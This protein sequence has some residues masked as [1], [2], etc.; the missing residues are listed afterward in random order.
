MQLNE[1]SFYKPDWILGRS[2]MVSALWLAAVQPPDAWLWHNHVQSELYST[3]QHQPNLDLHHPSNLQN[4][5]WNQ[6]QSI[7]T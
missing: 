1:E 6:F 7:F 4:T 2:P 5:I 3:K